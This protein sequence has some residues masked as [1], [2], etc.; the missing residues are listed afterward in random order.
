MGHGLSLDEAIASAPR[1]D[2]AFSPLTLAW[3]LQNFDLPSLAAAIG[4][5]DQELERLDRFRL[6]LI[7]RLLSQP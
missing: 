6:D 1:K 3:V 7:E 2:G 4:V 5:P